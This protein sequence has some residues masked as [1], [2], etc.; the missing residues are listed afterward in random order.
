LENYPSIRVSQEQINAAA[1]GISLARTAYL[2]RVDPLAQVNRAT[3]NN[4][5][6]V[7]LPQSAIPSISGGLPAGWSVAMTGFKAALSELGNPAGHG[8]AKSAAKDRLLEWS[9]VPEMSQRYDAVR[10]VIVQH[11]TELVQ[12][13]AARKPQ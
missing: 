5:F 6:E 2:P 4:V 13:L 9:D 10:K 7:M 12:K 1:A 3:R 8:S 11:V